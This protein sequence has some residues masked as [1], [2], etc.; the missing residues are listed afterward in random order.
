MTQENNIITEKTLNRM[1]LVDKTA[2][3]NLLVKYASQAYISTDLLVELTSINIALVTSDIEFLK[4][5]IYIFESGTE[6][7]QERIDYRIK[8]SQKVLEI[9][10]I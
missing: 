1:F 2:L 10:E 9:V 8:E 5:S 3:K 4:G 6:S 7:G